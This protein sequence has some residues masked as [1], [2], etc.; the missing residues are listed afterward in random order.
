MFFAT[1][2]FTY[3]MN[4]NAFVHECMCVFASV[5]V[6]IFVYD[7]ACSFACGSWWLTVSPSFYLKEFYFILLTKKEFYFIVYGGARA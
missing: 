2:T 5:C 4:S 7:D 1:F 3:M 6:Y